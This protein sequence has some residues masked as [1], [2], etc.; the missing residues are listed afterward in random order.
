MKEV[1]AENQPDSAM[2]F[3]IPPFV[4][5]ARAKFDFIVRSGNNVN[6]VEK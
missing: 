3:A 5:I 1:G 6:L 2:I 4:K